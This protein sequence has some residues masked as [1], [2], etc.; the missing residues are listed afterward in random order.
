M[1]NLAKLKGRHR[2]HGVRREI[3]V[4]RALFLLASIAF[5][6]GIALAPASGEATLMAP[7]SLDG[8]PGITAQVESPTSPEPAAAPTGTA[9]SAPTPPSPAEGESTPTLESLPAR[10]GVVNSS[11]EGSS[12]LGS[13]ESNDAGILSVCAPS[14][15]IIGGIDFGTSRWTL[16]G[17][18]TVL[19]NLQ[20]D[21]NPG[22]EGC[23]GIEP[24]WGIRISASALFSNQTGEAISPEHV[25]FIGS[26]PDSSPP[27]GVEPA[28]GSSTTL[29]ELPASIAITTEADPGGGVWSTQLSL[30]PPDYTSPGIYEGTITID[31]VQS[32]G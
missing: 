10:T 29:G 15:S 11:S 23:T 24:D 6:A 7:L 28:V 26:T 17:Y 32:S 14:A 20:I 8:T 21:I 13:A 25:S 22:E 18:E 9:P 19:A 27:P 12:P 2:K 5:V 16:T 30:S 31:V 4:R 1:R 3:S